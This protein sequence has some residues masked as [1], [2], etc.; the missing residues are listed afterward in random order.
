VELMIVIA[1]IGLLSAIA[2]PN[3]IFYR[4]KGQVD[5]VAANL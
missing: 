5:Q 4:K 1:V 2:V 3:Y